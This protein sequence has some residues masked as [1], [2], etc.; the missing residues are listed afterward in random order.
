MHQ[1]LFA[2]DDPRAAAELRAFAGS[3]LAVGELNVRFGRLARFSTGQPVWTYHSPG[4][5]RSVLR[6][7]AK[8]WPLDYR[9]EFE[10]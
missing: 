8:R 5:Q 1:W 3:E 6:Q 7:L 9:P 2:R 4:F 10:A